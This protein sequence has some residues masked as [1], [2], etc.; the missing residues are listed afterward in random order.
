MASMRSSSDDLPSPTAAQA[1]QEMKLMPGVPEL[2]AF[3]DQQGIPRGL[4][5]R[6]V[7][8]RLPTKL[9]ACV[10]ALILLRSLWWHV[11]RHAWSWC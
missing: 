7:K 3:L 9:N 1:L 6:N 8:V 4:I 11:C 2:C 10:Q 5:T